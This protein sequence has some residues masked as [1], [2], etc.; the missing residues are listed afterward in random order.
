MKTALRAVATVMCLCLPLG[1]CLDLEQ[2]IVLQPDLSGTASVRMTMDM[3]GM[4]PVIAKMQKEMKGEQGEPTE[5]EL[6]EVKKEILAKQ[7]QERA[8]EDAQLEEKR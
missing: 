7:E 8:E 6:A 5:A 4:I 2:G 3:N 1:G